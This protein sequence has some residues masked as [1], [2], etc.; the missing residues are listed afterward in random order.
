MIKRFILLGWVICSSFILGV[1][2]PEYLL[3]HSAKEYFDNDQYEEALANT[4]ELIEE[5][6]TKP[7]YF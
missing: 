4:L 7:E 1:E 2:L 3:N 5:H 6:P